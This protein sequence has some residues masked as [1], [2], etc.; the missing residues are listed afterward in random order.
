MEKLTK[1][2]YYTAIKTLIETGSCDINGADIIV[3]CDNEIALLNKKAVK[4]KE[5][6]AA[7]KAEGDALAEIVKAALSADTF[8]SI[9]DITAKVEAEDAT[10]SKV[11]YR[12]SK[13]V[14]AGVAVKQSIQ[15]PGVDGGKTRTVQGYKLA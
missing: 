7:K 11:T 6:Q 12:L 1:R 14:E 2:D 15:V 9:P 5:R 10:V 4:A 8:E 3:F 13:L